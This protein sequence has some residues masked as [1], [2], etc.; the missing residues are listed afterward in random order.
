M[1]LLVCIRRQVVEL[2][3][4]SD[5]QEALIMA[6]NPT[7]SRRTRHIELRWHFVREQVEK[8]A[9]H[10]HMQMKEPAVSLRTWWP[11][12]TVVWV[13]RSLVKWNRKPKQKTGGE[14]PRLTTKRIQH[15]ETPSEEERVERAAAHERGRPGY[16][17]D[18]IMNAFQKTN[19]VLDVNGQPIR[20]SDVKIPRNHRETIRSKYADFW[21]LA[22]LEEMAALKAKGV[23]KEI[24]GSEIPKDARA[25]NTIWVYALKFYLH[26]YI[27]RFKGRTVAL[28]NH[29]R[30]GIDFQ[31]IFSPVARIS[32][33]RLFLALAAV[34]NLLVFGGDINTAYLNA[35]LNIPQYVRSIPGNTISYVLIYVDDILVATN[36]EDF[37]V[38]LFSDLDEVYGIKD[39]GLL[40]QYLGIKVSQ[41]STKITIR[42]EK[43]ARE[44]LQ[45]FGKRYQFP[46]RE[47]IGMLMYLATST[48]PDLAFVVSQLSRF[49]AKPSTKHVGTL[50]RV[51]RYLRLDQ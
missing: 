46:Y 5:N 37:K 27:I 9:I 31:E 50:K 24:P 36:R 28:G 6:T 8:G 16:M 13:S 38:K 44:I 21:T 10:L 2:K 1:D 30:P 17:D 4:G 34:L 47:V 12:V 33:F 48:R 49:V 41:T 18:Y 35:W 51:L 14:T 29:Q 32:S 42:Q 23:L 26:G 25:I 20:A 7:Y 39:Q 11:S 43:Y 19:R 15:D 45:K 40:S 3:L 22:E